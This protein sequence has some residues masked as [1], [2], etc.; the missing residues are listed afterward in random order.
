[1]SPVLRIRM[2][3]LSEPSI[4]KCLFTF[5]QQTALQTDSVSVSSSL[6]FTGSQPHINGNVG[7]SKENWYRCTCRGEEEGRTDRDSIECSR[8]KKWNVEFDGG[9]TE[10]KTS[11]S[12]KIYKAAYTNLSTPHKKTAA[13]VIRAA[14][15]TGHGVEDKDQV[16]HR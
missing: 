12:L 10:H 11:Q 7:R 5:D 6:F 13:T 9:T 3:C 1:M 2:C 8:A 15:K 16:E 14:P 4:G